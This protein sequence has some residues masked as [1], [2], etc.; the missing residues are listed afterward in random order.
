MIRYSGVCLILDP[1]RFEGLRETLRGEFGLV[2]GRQITKTAESEVLVWEDSSGVGRWRVHLT[3][4]NPLGPSAYF[5]YWPERINEKMWEDPMLRV[6]KQV[7][8]SLNES[9][10]GAFVCDGSIGKEISRELE[11]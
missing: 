7:Y 2:P 3:P 11:N 5:H 6:V 8:G 1:E 9:A 4:K 10:I